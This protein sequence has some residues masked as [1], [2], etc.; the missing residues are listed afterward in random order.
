MRA[1]PTAALAIAAALMVGSLCTTA[2][3]KLNHDLINLPT[4]H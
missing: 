4:H 1:L 2:M 3:T